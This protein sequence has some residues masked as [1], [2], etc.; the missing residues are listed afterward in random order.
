MKAWTANDEVPIDPAG[1]VPYAAVTPAAKSAH[2]LRLRV[3]NLEAALERAER[4]R[5]H[6][7]DAWAEAQV[8]LDCGADATEAV[9]E[10]RAAVVAWLRALAVE[11]RSEGLVREN[12]ALCEAAHDIAAG[13]HRPG[14]DP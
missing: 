6:F 9:R 8:R 11:C 2:A 1:A 3:A 5:D 4:E 13:R 14:G 12:Y 7:R 10:E